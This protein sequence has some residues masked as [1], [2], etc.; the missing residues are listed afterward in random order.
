MRTVPKVLFASVAVMAFAP[1]SDEHVPFEFGKMRATL[2]G[3]EFAGS[4]GRDSTLAVWIAPI[5][6]LQIEGDKRVHVLRREMIRLTMRCA[7]LPRAGTYSIGGRFSPVSAEA[8]VGPTLWERIWPLRGANYRAF[9]SD[10]MSQG[11]LILDAVDSANAIVEGH[12]SVALR[13]VNRSPETLLVRGTFFGRVDLIERS[14][15]HE[16]K[17]PPRFRT[18]CERIRDAVWM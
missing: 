1:R 6:Q 12:F 7:A 2:N 8:L 10:P 9:F 14:S 15:R 5:G 16:A 17:W 11:V 13:G 18:D 3:R 4:F